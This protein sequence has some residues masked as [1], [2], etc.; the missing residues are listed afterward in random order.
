M[1]A[2]PALIGAISCGPT[3][4][5]TDGNPIDV[6]LPPEQ[7]AIEQPEPVRTSDGGWEFVL[8]PLARYVLRGIVVSRTTY[9]FDWN[10]GLSPYDV[11]MV[12]GDLAAGDAWRAL[13]WSQSGRWYFWRWSGAPPLPNETIVRNSSNTHIVP[14]S[15]NLARAARSLEEGDLAEL[16]GDLVAIEARK[17]SERAHWRSSL[18]R[19]DT[20]DGSCELLYLRKVRVGGKVYE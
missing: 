17:G 5:G 20:G 12:W 4:S 1:V 16:S 11:A 8:T 19:N 6:S 13:R 10:T 14:A 7:T 2:A 3:P 18:S 15:L 9:R